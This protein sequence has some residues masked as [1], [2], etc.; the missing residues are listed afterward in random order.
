M[1]CETSESMLFQKAS[2]NAPHNSHEIRSVVEDTALL[3]EGSLDVPVTCKD[4]IKYLTDGLGR[5]L[6][7]VER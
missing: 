7:R 4:L 1:Q 2:K 6:L 3:L 5:F